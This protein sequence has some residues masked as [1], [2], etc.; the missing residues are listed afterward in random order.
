MLA[1]LLRLTA[2]ATIK[3]IATRTKS[4]PKA[5]WRPLRARKYAYASVWKQN[6][7]AIARRRI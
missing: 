5:W 2:V 1:S 6:A 3:G 7:A 4:T